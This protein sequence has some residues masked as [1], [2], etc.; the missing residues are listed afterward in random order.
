MIIHY[1]QKGE[2]LGDIYEQAISIFTN[3]KYSNVISCCLITKIYVNS[4]YTSSQDLKEILCVAER[5]IVQENVIC[6]S[7]ICIFSAMQMACS[8]RSYIFLLH[9]IYNTNTL[10]MDQSFLYFV[11]AMHSNMLL[12]SND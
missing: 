4:L 11:S 10:Q 2:R 12:R 6:K 9:L 8:F 7:C 3:V 1:A 5:L